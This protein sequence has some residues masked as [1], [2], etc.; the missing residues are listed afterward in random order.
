[1]LTISD[2]TGPGKVSAFWSLPRVDR[3]PGDVLDLRNGA[4]VHHGILSGI[5]HKRVIL[6]P[7]QKSWGRRK[8]VG[9]CPPYSLS[10]GLPHLRHS[11]LPIF[12]SRRCRCSR[13]ASAPSS[14]EVSIKT[15]AMSLASSFPKSNY[16][17]YAIGPP[18]AAAQTIHLLVWSLLPFPSVMR[19]FPACLGSASFSEHPDRVASR[20]LSSH[21]TTR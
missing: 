9:M 12:A 11:F 20:E 21:S 6:S 1:M 5:S 17:S 8:R 15:D 13:W 18:S 7:K 16:T 14:S 3:P 10:P 19:V 2:W 4:N